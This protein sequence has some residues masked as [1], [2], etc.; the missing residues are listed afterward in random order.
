MADDGRL[1]P[2]MPAA[3]VRLPRFAGRRVH[4][5]VPP[6][7]ERLEDDLHVVR[8]FVGKPA[9][10]APVAEAVRAEVDRLEQLRRRLEVARLQGDRIW[11]NTGV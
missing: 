11:S 4:E 8:I 10:R 5:P 7:D 3:A 1:V 2:P 9:R 6:L